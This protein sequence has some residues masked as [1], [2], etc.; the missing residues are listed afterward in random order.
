MSKGGGAPM[1]AQSG[2]LRVWLVTGTLPSSLFTMTFMAPAPEQMSCI[3]CG[4]TMGEAIATPIDKANQTST[5]RA[6][7][8]ALRRFCMRGLLQVQKWAVNWPFVEMESKWVI[9]R[10]IFAS[11]TCS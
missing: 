3:P 2:Q 4:M 1:L 8:L 6:M 7:S 11:M 5:K 10:T 9:F